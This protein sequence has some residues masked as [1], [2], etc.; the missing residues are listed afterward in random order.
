[1]ETARPWNYGH[2]ASRRRSKLPF[3]NSDSDICWDTIP[4]SGMPR[5][6]VKLLNR[7][8]VV[9]EISTIILA[10]QLNKVENETLFFSRLGSALTVSDC[11]TRKLRGLIMVVSIDYISRE[12]LGDDNLKSLP[13]KTEEK[14]LNTACRKGKKKP[15]NSKRINFMPNSPRVNSALPEPK[16]VLT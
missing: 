9:Q 13:N 8:L 7:L 2:V 14:R 5:H 10:C 15:R 12:L 3:L 1:M 11:I 6:L 16:M 4:C